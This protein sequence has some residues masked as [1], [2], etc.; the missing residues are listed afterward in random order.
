[1]KDE[2]NI[3]LTVSLEDYLEAIYNISCE[4]N[5]EYVRITDISNRLKKSKPSVNISIK[6]LAKN[7][8]LIHEHYGGIILTEKG[9]ELAKEITFR[10][11]TIKRFFID[12]LKIKP[13]IADKE[14]CCIEHV[15]SDSSM[16]KFASYI[17]AILKK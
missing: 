13:D 15:M 5:T 2:K 3:K 1:M 7:G 9:I 10:H 17:E 16:K 14:A 12:V 11:N 6:I 4:N 8:Y